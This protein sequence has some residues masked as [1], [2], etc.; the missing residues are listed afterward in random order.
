MFFL[1]FFLMIE[2]SGSGTVSQTKGS[3][4][5]RP[6]NIGMD[7]TDPDP[8]HCFDSE[9]IYLP[10]KLVQREKVLTSLICVERM[11]R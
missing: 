1:L 7:P 5:G 11:P 10:M 2:V 6:K 8:P 9:H 3:G 4:S